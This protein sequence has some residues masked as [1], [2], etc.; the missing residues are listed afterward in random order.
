MLDK[1]FG[2]VKGERLENKHVRDEDYVIV[3]KKEC[4]LDQPNRNGTGRE[5][6]MA[7]E[8]LERVSRIRRQS[9][10]E[11]EPT[12]RPQK[13]SEAKEKKKPSKRKWG[14]F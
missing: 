5:S 6:L 9:A 2:K 3:N 14:L 1:S 13:S 10:G 11:E 7:K 12:A 4:A 8:N